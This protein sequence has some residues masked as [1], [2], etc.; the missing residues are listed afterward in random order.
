MPSSAC[1]HCLW[2]RGALALR[3]KTAGLLALPLPDFRG[4]EGT[5]VVWSMC[6][7]ASGF[8][9]L[10]VSAAQS[11]CEASQNGSTRRMPMSCAALLLRISI[12]KYARVH[13]SNFLLKPTRRTVCSRVH[14]INRIEN[15]RIA[16]SVVLLLVGR[17][18]LLAAA[19]PRVSKCPRFFVRVE[20]SSNQLQSATVEESVASA[21]VR[22]FPRLFLF[23][24][25]KYFKRDHAPLAHARVAPTHHS[26]HPHLQNHRNRTNCLCTT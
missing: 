26:N 11:F 24:A 12:F 18:L 5:S 20:I 16:L 14:R 7:E 15:R 22:I 4:C 10:P 23:C 17:I 1:H 3:T 13:H 19:T 8:L 9:C 21:V 2:L 25:A 6:K